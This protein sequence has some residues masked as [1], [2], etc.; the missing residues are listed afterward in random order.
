MAT[1]LRLY[2]FSATASQD[3]SLD[4][5]YAA[6]LKQLCP[7]GSTNP[8]LVVPMDTNSPNDFNDDYYE[9]ILVNRGLFTSDQTLLSSPQSA[10]LVMR[11]A[12]NSLEWKNKFSAATVK[13]GQLDVLTGSAGEI[14]ANCRVDN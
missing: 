6:Q 3:P 13:M 10:R 14:R 7:Q 2:N 9:A 8:D 12:D 11:Y 1:R 5:K 4:P